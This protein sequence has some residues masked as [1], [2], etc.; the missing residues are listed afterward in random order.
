MGATFAALVEHG[1]TKPPTISAG[2][3]YALTGLVLLEG[4]PRTWTPISVADHT[5]RL[6]VSREALMRGYKEAEAAG[7]VSRESRKEPGRP[8][9]GYLRFE[10]PLIELI[11]ESMDKKKEES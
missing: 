7:L 5:R 9:K 11:D 6:Q 10:E 3:V 8:R 2:V 1:P 4:V